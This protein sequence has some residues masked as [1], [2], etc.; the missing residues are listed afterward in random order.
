MN[1]EYLPQK[2]GREGR[3]Q[4][5]SRPA[6]HRA[7]P[8]MLSRI[9]GHVAAAGAS[10]S[11]A[12]L[13]CKE[14]LQELDDCG[15]TG[16]VRFGTVSSVVF[17]C[18]RL[19]CCLRVDRTSAGS[20]RSAGWSVSWRFNAFAICSQLC[21]PQAVSH[22]RRPAG[23]FRGRSTKVHCD[24]LFTRQAASHFHFH[25]AAGTLELKLIL[26]KVV[27]WAVPLRRKLWHHRTTHQTIP[28]TCYNSESF[29]RS[30]HTTVFC[31]PEV[32]TSLQYSIG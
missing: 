4:L 17:R 18:A 15:Q 32:S 6:S 8:G 24:S 7:F 21:C 30:H 19:S 28:T 3:P 31:F 2:T 23:S 12:S 27:F 5:T 14:W 22:K 1:K 9:I 16:F 29:R 10:S 13:A 20:V 11:Y 25:L 26:I